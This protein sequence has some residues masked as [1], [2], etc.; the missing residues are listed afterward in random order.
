MARRRQAE[1]SQ[2]TTAEL[3]EAA[4]KSFGRD[5]YAAVSIDEVAAAAG[6]TK[7]AVYHHF[8]G[9]TALFAAVFTRAQE[10]LAERLVAEASGARDG[11]EA[12][13]LGAH[14][15]LR[16]CMDPAVRQII[17]LDGPAVLGRD[18]VREIEDEHV[19]ALLTAGLRRAERDGGLRPGDAALRGRLLLGALCEAALVLAR[20][21]EPEREF[22]AVAAEVDMLLGAYG[23]E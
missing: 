12:V 6:V 10:Q 20:S 21:A 15:F 19:T 13:R 11:W 5:G 3:V 1:R 8:A 7:G 2:A 4:A 18:A 16:A 22:A 9:K 14:A 23:G 17:V